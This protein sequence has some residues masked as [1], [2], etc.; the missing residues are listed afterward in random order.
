LAGTV[1]QPNDKSLQID[2]IKIED[3]RAAT[4]KM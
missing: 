4:V 1:S 2:N 3:R